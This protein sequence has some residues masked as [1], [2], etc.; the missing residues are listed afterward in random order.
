MCTL[1][2]S[3]VLMYNFHYNY[4]KIKYGNKSKQLFTATDV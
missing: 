2:L 4:V 1:E 3:K